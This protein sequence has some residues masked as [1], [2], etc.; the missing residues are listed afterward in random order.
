MADLNRLLNELTHKY[1]DVRSRA[2]FL[3]H[4]CRL[5]EELDD[6]YMAFGVQEP[7]LSDLTTFSSLIGKLKIKL[8][9]YP[10]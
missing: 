8:S 5:V 4:N 10:N 2:L 7:N 1:L 9:Y 3:R 6:C